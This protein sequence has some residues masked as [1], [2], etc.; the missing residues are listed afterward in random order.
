MKIA[1]CLSGYYNS[2]KDSLSFG[3]DGFSHIKKHILKYSEE[4]YE[5]D[6]FFHNWEPHL[7]SKIT[8]LYKPKAYITEAQIDFNQIAEDNQVSRKFIDEHNKLGSWT[9]TS[10]TGGGYVGP[11]RILSQFYSIQKSFELKKKYE[12]END[13]SY[14]CAIKAR[15]DL[16]RINRLTSGPGKINP[17]PCQCIKFDPELDMNYF[18]QAYWDLFNEGP[19]DMWFYSSS[20]NMNNFCNFYTKTLTEYLQ[21]ESEYSKR[22]VEGWPESSCNNFRT[23][24]IFK[25]K[26]K[27]SKDLHKYEP[28][29]AVNGILLHKWFLMDHGLWEKAKAL[30]S[31]W[32]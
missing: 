23:N 12:E 30:H 24:E 2:I 10:R 9:M 7:E 11:E 32:E 27:Q 28:Y 29:L 19:A 5:I 8:D 26:N 4:G 20:S 31:K 21:R 17:Y 25:P 14:D 15:F 18:Y 1:L 3:D 22:V 13:F 16:G 6:V